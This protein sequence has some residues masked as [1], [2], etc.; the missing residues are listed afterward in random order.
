MAK[1]LTN[2]I[3]NQ[4][5]GT[6]ASQD[7]V[8]AQFDNGNDFARK[9]DKPELPTLSS[10]PDSDK[11]PPMLSVLNWITN[12]FVSLSLEHDIPP[13]AMRLLPSSSKGGIEALFKGFVEKWN[14]V[15]GKTLERHR[16]PLPRVSVSPTANDALE[17]IFRQLISRIRDYG[18]T[19]FSRESTFF[20]TLPDA[21][22]VTFPP[23]PFGGFTHEELYQAG[24]PRQLQLVR[25][26]SGPG[27]FEIAWV[28]KHLE[29]SDN[30]GRAYNWANNAC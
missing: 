7:V 1:S 19:D 3:W 11:D 20:T 14:R 27:G 9:F 8:T 29:M 23:G 12:F 13:T 26:K 22:R 25:V 30:H 4:A 16:A 24:S 10:S 17:R 15:G 18:P 2:V 28:G 5:R 6:T 21:Q